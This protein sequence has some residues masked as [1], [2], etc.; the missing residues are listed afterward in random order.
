MI[1]LNS[2]DVFSAEKSPEMV[3]ELNTL[4][5][6]SA[7]TPIYFKTEIIIS[8]LK[9]HSIKN[10]WIDANPVLAKL[11]ISNACITKNIE[12]LFEFCRYNQSYMRDYETYIRTTVLIAPGNRNPL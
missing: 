7:H 8:Y 10:N 11:M 6:K 2:E 12:S 3:Q 5:E 9:N 1:K 4:K